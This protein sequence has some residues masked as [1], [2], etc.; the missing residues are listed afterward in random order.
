MAIKK[1]KKVL[2]F[3]LEADICANYYATETIN[4]NAFSALM[5]KSSCRLVFSNTK[6]N[7]VDIKVPQTQFVSFANC[8]ILNRGDLVVDFFES[9]KSPSEISVVIIRIYK[10]T[11]F[12]DDPDLGKSYISLQKYNQCELIYEKGYTKFNVLN[13]E[14]DPF[15][16]FK[17]IPTFIRDLI[18]GFPA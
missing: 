14:K 5:L 1:I 2:G 11:E 4:I 16:S 9:D 17:K 12:L 6:E 8:V 15:E 13:W 18:E 7:G 10:I 3:R